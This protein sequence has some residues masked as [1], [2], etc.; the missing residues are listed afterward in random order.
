MSNA[1][2]PREVCSTTIGTSGLTVLASFRVWRP[3][4]SRRAGCARSS[5]RESSVRLSAARAGLD[6]WSGR[7][8]EP[9][10]GVCHGPRDGAQEPRVDLPAVVARA[11]VAAV[12][13]GE[14]A[15]HRDARA[16]EGGVVGGAAETLLAGSQTGPAQGAAEHSLDRVVG[17]VDLCAAAGRAN[18]VEVQVR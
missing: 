15:P 8:G 13:P 5:R 1:R 9:P 3:N 17:V 10:G 6:P 14:D 7:L 12:Q 4:P 11:V 16:R 2:S 18:H